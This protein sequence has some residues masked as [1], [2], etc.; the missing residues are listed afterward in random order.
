MIVE[1]HTLMNHQ[2]SSFK[3]FLVFSQNE[4]PNEIIQFQTLT[5]N[6]DKTNKRTVWTEPI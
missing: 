6:K 1:L 5:K 3:V 2:N 4:R